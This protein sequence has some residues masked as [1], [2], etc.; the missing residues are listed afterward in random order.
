MSGDA[1]VGSSGVSFTAHNI[2]LGDGRFSISSDKGAISAHPVFRYAKEVL[3][4]KYATLAG[5]SLCDLGCLEG[6]Y[7]LEFARLGMRVTGIE[8]RKS[9]FAACEFIRRESVGISGELV[10]VNDDA[11][12]MA[13]YGAH[14][15]V[16]CCGLLYHLD[17]PLDFLRL[18]YEHCGDCLI[19]D[20]HFSRKDKK[21][22]E[23]QSDICE[24]EG[25]RGRW[26]V[27]YEEGV[28]EKNEKAKWTAWA[29]RRSFW[30]LKEELFRALEIVGFR[31]AREIKAPTRSIENMRVAILADK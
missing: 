18:L 3:L 26:F 10:F 25:L 11:W 30:P 7:S 27:E 6:G 16:F 17:R 29:N 1:S 23:S 8:V 20:T 4:K 22:T 5:R 24:N 13:Q 12:N 14:D 21:F 19:L 31:S 2:D 9:N 28:A 15:V